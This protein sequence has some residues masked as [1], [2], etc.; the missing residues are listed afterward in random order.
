MAAAQPQR[1]PQHQPQQRT[2]KVVTTEQE[3]SRPA[4]QEG[5]GPPSEPP[6]PPQQQ[7]QWVN[8]RSS[9]A[10]DLGTAAREARESRKR[11]L[12]GLALLLLLAVGAVAAGL[13]VD[14]DAFWVAAAPVFGAAGTGLVA[15]GGKRLGVFAETAQ[16]LGRRAEDG[17]AAVGGALTEAER[18]R[19]EEAMLRRVCYQ[20]GADLA[21]GDQQSSDTPRENKLAARRAFAMAGWY[22]HPEGQR[23]S[24]L[25]TLE[26]EGEDSKAAREEA[27]FSL[28]QA[29]TMK[30]TTA[31]YNLGAL[32]ARHGIGK[33]SDRDRLLAYVSGRGSV[34]AAF[35]VGLMDRSEEA[36]Y[37]PHAPTQDQYIV[38]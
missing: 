23:R 21:S 30:S 17:I 24:A 13:V 6:E 36:L 14:K 1:Q 19:A 27:F 15:Y 16:L 22:E 31:A 34:L 8:E 2:T 20:I 3:E 29:S 10:A 37:A 33:Q 28:L 35:I 12:E 38:L 9:L 7:D 11:V 26:L 4:P 18:K 32:D 5:G 25:L